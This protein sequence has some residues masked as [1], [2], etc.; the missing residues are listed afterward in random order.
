MSQG[1]CIVTLSA[2]LQ[3]LKLYSCIISEKTLS[4]CFD[5]CFNLLSA[6]FN[7]FNKNMWINFLST[8]RTTDPIP[9]LKRIKLSSLNI[10]L[11]TLFSF[12]KVFFANDFYFF[13]LFTL[14]SIFLNFSYFFEYLFRYSVFVLVCFSKI[15]KIISTHL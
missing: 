9:T 7:I 12:F 11:D 2:C 6:C 4:A 3:N 15:I 13:Y 1:R 10:S 14:T 8:F 5:Y